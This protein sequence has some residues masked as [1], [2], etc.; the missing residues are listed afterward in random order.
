[1][2]QQSHDSDLSLGERDDY[3]LLS[4]NLVAPVLDHDE[5]PGE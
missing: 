2:T 4:T 1:M 3:D 5:E